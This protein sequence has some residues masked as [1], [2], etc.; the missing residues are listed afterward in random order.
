LASGGFVL[1]EHEFVVFDESHQLEDVMAATLGLEL[2]AG[3]FRFLARALRGVVVDAPEAALLDD[4]GARLEAAIEPHRG[5]RLQADAMAPVAEVLVQGG[6]RVA[7]ALARLRDLKPPP[8]RAAARRERALKMCTGLAED[9]AIA[10]VPGE[11]DVVWVEGP[12]H[13]PVLRVAPV[14]VGS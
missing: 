6:E 3:R 10:A 7:R 4:A 11:N 13:A 2:G 8:G 5:A 14:D 1:G 12:P 9:L